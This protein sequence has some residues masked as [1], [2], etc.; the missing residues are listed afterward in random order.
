MHFIAEFVVTG[1]LAHCILPF[2]GIP[3]Q[4]CSPTQCNCKGCKN[5]KNNSG[6]NGARTKAIKECLGRNENAFGPRK[7]NSGEGCSCKK[8]NCLKKYCVSVKSSM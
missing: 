2:L 1:S 5:T 3:W 4:I 6:P 8:T 7:R